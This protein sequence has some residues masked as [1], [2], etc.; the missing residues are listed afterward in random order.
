MVCSDA[1]QLEKRL[2]ISELETRLSLTAQQA[3]KL[4]PPSLFKYAG[5]AVQRCA[6]VAAAEFGRESRD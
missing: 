2:K 4:G 6:A 5:T 1:G 3:V